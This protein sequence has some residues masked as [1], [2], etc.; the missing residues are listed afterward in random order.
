MQIKANSIFSHNSKTE[1]MVWNSG[2][3]KISDD[4]AP[5]KLS[6]MQVYCNNNKTTRVRVVAI[7]TQSEITYL[8]CNIL[9]TA[10]L[11]WSITIF[12]E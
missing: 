7:C 5:V 6:Q 9:K 10:P 3:D 4:I 11:Q 8:I 1:S 2:E 12:P